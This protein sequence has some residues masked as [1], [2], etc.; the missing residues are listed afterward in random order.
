MLK[1]LTQNQKLALGIGLII[2]AILLPILFRRSPKNTIQNQQIN[3]IIIKKGDQQITISKHGQVTIKSQGRLIMQY[4][5]QNKIDNIFEK[6]NQLGQ[7]S[8]SFNNGILTIDLDN[9]EQAQEIVE[10]EIFD[11]EVTEEIAELLTESVLPTPTPTT[12]FPTSG[13]ENPTPTLIPQSGNSSLTPTSPQAT[14]TDGQATPTQKPFKCIFNE[15]EA[16]QNPDFIISETV[17][18]ELV[19]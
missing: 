18:S 19:D 6:I 13:S 11:D 14:Q 16:G 8:F 3:N 1:K 4:W 15:P 10:L 2:I 12:F 9:E 5:S 17:C 7:T